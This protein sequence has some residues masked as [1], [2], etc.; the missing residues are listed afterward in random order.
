MFTFTVRILTVT[1][2]VD[3][4][5]DGTCGAA[6]ARGRLALA[7]F[8][9]AHAIEEIAW[10]GY[11]RHFA[12]RLRWGRCSPTVRVN[13][14]AFQVQKAA[15]EVPAARNLIQMRREMCVFRHLTHCNSFVLL[16]KKRAWRGSRLFATK[17]G[18]GEGGISAKITIDSHGLL[19]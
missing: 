7:F 1:S 3:T 15:S 12:D 13:L 9:P 8:F 5:L 4:T 6:D 16:G 17:G 18:G 10:M 2:R 14:V 19:R 11:P